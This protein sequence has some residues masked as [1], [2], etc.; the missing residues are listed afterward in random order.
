M[1]PIV[2][3]R[4]LLVVYGLAWLCLGAL[5]TLVTTGAESWLASGALA[6]PQAALLGLLCLAA[7]Y[8]CRANPLPASRGLRLGLTHL[9]GAVVASGL[10]LLTGS[11]L[12]SLL[13]RFAPT[14]AAAAVF[15]RER[16]LYFAVGFV[17]YLLVVAC[18]YLILLASVAQAAQGRALALRAAAREAE[19]VALRAQIDPH[20]L[21]NSLNSVSALCG[22]DPAGARRMTQSLADFFRASR[23][24]GAAEVV[25]LAAELALAEQ[26]LAIE[27]VRFG[28]RLRVE[29]QVDPA[30]LQHPVPPLLLQP[31]VEN[32]VRHGVA[33]AVEGGAI[34]L[35]GE[36]TAHGCR[37]RISNPL[38]PAASGA[39]RRRGGGLGLANVR[40]RLRLT[41]GAQARL[42]SH[43]EGESFVVEISLPAPPVA[44]G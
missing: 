28:D 44:G 15:A 33:P 11:V 13:A 2:A 38:P 9:G 10:W 24:A 19:L 21:F 27:Q 42:S 39:G 14:S 4:G 31:L 43:A 36:L 22:S 35:R 6:L 18:Y 32:A 17:L 20:F 5:L 8:P 30:L 7:W 12:S 23:A 41:Y 37:L 34:S 29:M 3:R 1:H 26:Y 25:P 40:Q 16:S